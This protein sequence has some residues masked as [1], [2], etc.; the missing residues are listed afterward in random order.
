MSEDKLEASW[1]FSLLSCYGRPGYQAIGWL[2]P[3]LSLC[4]LV[5]GLLRSGILFWR[6]EVFATEI[7]R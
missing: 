5:D 1:L 4:V 7:M 3:V 6:H 2:Q